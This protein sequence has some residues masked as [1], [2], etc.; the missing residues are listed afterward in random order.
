MGWYIVTKTIKGHRYRYRQRS[1]R[2]NG[3]M[4]TENVYLGPIGGTAPPES[5][6]TISGGASA[7]AN[8]AQAAV[9][10]TRDRRDGRDISKKLGLK[11]KKK[12][13]PPGASKEPAIRP[14]NPY[15]GKLLGI[16]HDRAQPAAL[17]KRSAANRKH[18]KPLVSRGK[19][20]PRTLPVD[21]NFSDHFWDTP[22]TI[23]QL[24]KQAAVFYKAH[25]ELGRKFSGINV[26]TQ[27]LSGRAYRDWSQM[28]DLKETLGW[29]QRKSMSWFARRLLYTKNGV[30]IKREK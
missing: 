30:V 29:Y 8:K 22:K 28:Q 15:I 3:K 4:R 19:R 26:V 25:Q 20:E 16:Y 18:A 21:G 23:G 6:G 9:N 5:K 11:S 24:R 1:W 13:P 27:I 12:V 14:V 10:T 7:A 2:E 17:A